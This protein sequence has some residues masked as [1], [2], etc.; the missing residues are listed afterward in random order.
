MVARETQQRD[1]GNPYRRTK[2][3]QSNCGR[4]GERHQ[5]VYREHRAKVSNLPSINP[6]FSLKN[7]MN[8]KFIKVVVRSFGAGIKAAVGTWFKDGVGCHK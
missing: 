6:N 7:W 4:H 5:H 3:E 2:R 1:Q 8:V